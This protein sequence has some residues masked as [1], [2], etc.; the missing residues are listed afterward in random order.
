MIAAWDLSAVAALAGIRTPLGVEV[1]SLLTNLG[2][3]VAVCGVFIAAFVLVEENKRS[4]Y[5]AGMLIALSASLAI[6]EEAKALIQRDRP[7][8]A[9]R[10]VYEIGYSFPS[11]HATAAAALYG[12]LAFAAW[13]IGPRRYRRTLVVL[14]LAAIALV[15]ASRVYLGVHYPTDVLAGCALGIV[16]AG[17]GAAVTRA[18]ERRKKRTA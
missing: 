14:C 3:A 18:L 10:A 17:F 16:C 9:L 11:E 1:F 7:P 2:G 8:E 12:F 15:M 13:T 6:A 5:G 4:A